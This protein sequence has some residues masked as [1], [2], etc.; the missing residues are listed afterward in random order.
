MTIVSFVTFSAST[1]YL[2]VI[3][4]PSAVTIAKYTSLSAL[5]GNIARPVS[6]VIIY[7]SIISLFV[8]ASY[9]F[10]VAFEIGLP[11]EFNIVKL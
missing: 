1:E 11:S 6:L 2:F 3:I 7:F 8:L 5:I 4:V 9:A 10:I